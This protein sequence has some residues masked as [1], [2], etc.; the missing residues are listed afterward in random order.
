MI[1]ASARSL[2]AQV[3]EA[4]TA[5]VLGLFAQSY[6][7]WQV[8]ADKDGR[9]MLAGLAS[10]AM[11]PGAVAQVPCDKPA[12]VNAGPCA[13]GLHA[14]PSAVDQA[15]SMA[16]LVV[17]GAVR[18]LSTNHGDERR[19][20]AVVAVEGPLHLLSWCAGSLDGFSLER[21]DRTPRW[22]IPGSPAGSVCPRHLRGVSHPVRSRRVAVKEFLTAAA[23]DLHHRYGVDVNFDA[24]EQLARS[25]RAPAPTSLNPPS[26]AAHG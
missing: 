10:D 15:R 11:W 9:T 20:L 8:F 19:R 12:D 5:A 1:D 17:G 16:S 13:C 25:A 4:D 2:D 24:P 14:P 23:A 7:W 3:V 22:A 18:V 6:R 21:C 26:M